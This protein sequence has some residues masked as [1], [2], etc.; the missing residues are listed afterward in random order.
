MFCKRTS[1]V[2]EKLLCSLTL[3]ILVDVL[4]TR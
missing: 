1:R 3:Q 4:D 2:H